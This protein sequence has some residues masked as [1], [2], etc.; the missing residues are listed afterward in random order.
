VG[1]IGYKLSWGVAHRVLDL[2]G[3]GNARL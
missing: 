3:F 2:L 1:E